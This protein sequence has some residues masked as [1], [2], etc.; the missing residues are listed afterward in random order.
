MSEGLSVKNMKPRERISFLEGALT[1]ACAERNSRDA[2][3][4]SLRERL[5]GMEEQSEARR[6]ALLAVGDE[7]RVEWTRAENAEAERDAALAKL[8]EAERKGEELLQHV[9]GHPEMADGDELTALRE[10][11]RA[12]IEN[13]GEPRGKFAS[14]CGVCRALAAVA[15]ARGSK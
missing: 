8:A 1:R 10:L 5:A 2:E 6:R 15:R 4:A 13:H 9:A 14:D 12:S 7:R 11:E 3:L